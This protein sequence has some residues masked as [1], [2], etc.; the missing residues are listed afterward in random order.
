M[1]NE[2]H[3]VTTELNVSHEELGNR[4][5]AAR[6]YLAL[7]QDEVARAMRIPRSAVSL[8]EAGQRKVSA[9]ELRRLASLYERP[10]SFFTDGETVAA[11]EVGE[12]QHLAREASALSEKDLEEL[13]QF[14]RFLKE[15]RAGS[16]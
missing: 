6:E 2:G 9:I 8:M 15:R 12:I 11:F 1:T 4:L 5:K 16:K 7:S 3:N 13:M 14:A 10:V